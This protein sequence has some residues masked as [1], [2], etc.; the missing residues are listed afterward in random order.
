MK[1]L[2]RWTA[3]LLGSLLLSAPSGAASD[4]TPDDAP[5]AREELRLLTASAGAIRTLRSAPDNRSLDYLLKRARG[6]M[7]FP[8]VV[9]AGLLFGAEGGN[10][11]MAAR[12]PDGSWSAP[13]FY[14]MGGASVGLQLGVQRVTLILVFMDDRA[15]DRAMGKDFMLGADATLAAGDALAAAE[16]STASY[17]PDIYFFSSVEGLFMGAALTGKVMNL[18]DGA[19]R[20]FFG[21]SVAPEEI[22]RDGERADV[23]GA[24]ILRDALTPPGPEGDR[25]P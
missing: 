8:R 7:I 10:G 15:V 23:P 9:K 25:Q 16:V 6:V 4:A 22:L 14:A 5:N 2:L 24:N 17:S 13:V 1:S 19:N 11:L 18:D 12:L 3:I 20:A 21:D